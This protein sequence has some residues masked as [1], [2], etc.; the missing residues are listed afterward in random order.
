MR[1]DV[2]LL[3]RLRGDG[4]TE[5]SSAAL[6][7]T[8]LTREGFV[9]WGWCARLT[10]NF[11]LRNSWKPQE[12]TPQPSVVEMALPHSKIFLSFPLGVC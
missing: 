1:K 8:Y 3:S 2:R 10:I 11:C 7:K 12:S 5:G 9:D 6:V 4:D